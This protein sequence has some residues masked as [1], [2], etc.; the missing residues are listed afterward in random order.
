MTSPASSSQPIASKRC[1]EPLSST[2]A[3]CGLPPSNA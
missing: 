2:P 3:R 1:H